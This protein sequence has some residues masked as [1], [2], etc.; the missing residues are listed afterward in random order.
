MTSLNVLR[1]LHALLRPRVYVEVGIRGYVASSLAQSHTSVVKLEKLAG[2]AAHQDQVDLVLFSAGAKWPLLS[3][4]TGSDSS[5]GVSVCY[6]DPGEVMKSVAGYSQAGYSPKPH[7]VV[8]KDGWVAVARGGSRG[9]LSASAVDDAYRANVESRG[10][11][12]AELSA[13]QEYVMTSHS[14]A[15]TPG[16]SQLN[17]ATLHGVERCPCEVAV[18]LPAIDLPLARKTAVLLRERAGM[19]CQIYIVHDEQRN[20]LVSTV[21]KAYQAIQAPFYAFV[22]QDVFAGQDWLS[23]AHECLQNE[24]TGLFGFNDG[25]LGGSHA[26]FGLVRRT[27]AESIYGRHL[28]FP[29][30]QTHACDTELTLV[31]KQ[32]QAYSSDPA[33]ILL[34]VDYFK[35]YATSSYPD[36][37]LYRERKRKGFGGLVSDQALL[38]AY[39]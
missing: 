25:R 20:G 6:G 2:L 35:D 10:G 24:R 18:L 8:A 23:I 13:L 31:A 19:P 4:M 9:T 7:V 14:A 38:E 28:F 12:D 11:M 33:A 37:R 17:A 1:Y 21:N 26:S 27:W 30:Y 34:E 29:G 32:Q 3:E 22:A 36:V 15:A 39:A 16:V 5:D